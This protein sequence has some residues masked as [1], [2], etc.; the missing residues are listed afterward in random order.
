MN[1]HESPDSLI[2]EFVDMLKK[3]E[4]GE[5]APGSDIYKRLLTFRDKFPFYE[6]KAKQIIKE[7]SEE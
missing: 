6:E 7:Q 1:K 5:I 2:S 4:R 3:E